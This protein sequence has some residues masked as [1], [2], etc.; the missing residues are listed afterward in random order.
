[1]QIA[2]I[3]GKNGDFMEKK[4]NGIFLIC[5]I[6]AVAVTI[7]IMVFVS[8]KDVE[9]YQNMQQS[10]SNSEQ[11]ANDVQGNLDHVNDAIEAGYDNL[12]NQLDY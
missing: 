3:G 12:D 7:I 5:L 1:M 8:K 10:I 9:E 4:N 2:P 6:V 11:I